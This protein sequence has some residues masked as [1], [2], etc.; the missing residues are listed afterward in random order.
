MKKDWMPVVAGVLQIVSGVCAFIG[1]GAVA[2]SAAMFQWVPDMQEEDVPV[3][4]LTWLV[5]SLALFLGLLAAVGIIGG[6]FSVRRRGFG[7]AMAGSISALFT[8]MLLG[9]AALILVLVGEREFA[10]R[11]APASGPPAPQL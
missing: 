6:V 3:D 7:W 8:V 10:G 9:V 1:A 11:A 2:F 4:L 5:V